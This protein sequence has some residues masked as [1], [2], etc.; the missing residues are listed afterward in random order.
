MSDKS[1][2][3]ALRSEAQLV[4]IEAAAG[5]GKTYQAAEYARDLAP[6]LN[7]NRLLILT[8][9]HAACDVFAERTRDL[10]TQVEIRTIDSLISHIAGAYHLALGL[11][12]DVNAWAR[13]RPDGYT[14]LAT[15]VAALLE[16]APMVATAL[17]QRYPIVICDEHQDSN[18]SQHTIVV[19]IRNVGGRLRVFGDP[20]QSIYGKDTTAAHK[21]W[22]DFC[23][24]ADCVETLNEPHRWENTAAPLGQWIQ[25]ARGSLQRGVPIDLTG[26]L[27]LG[28]NIIRADN[29]AKGYGQYRVDKAEREPIDDVA[30]QRDMGTLVLAAHNKTVRSLCAFFFRRIPIWEGH[31]R[32]NLDLLGRKMS[33]Y[34]GNAHILGEAM[35]NFMKHVAVGFSPS[36]YGDRLLDEIDSRCTKTTRG[37]PK[38]I[39]EIARIILDSPDHHGISHALSR[40]AEL[41]ET[42]KRFNNIK[43]D[44]RHEFYEAIKISEFEESEI[45]IGE[46]AR[47]RTYTRPKPPLKAISTI[48]KAKG[49]ETDNVIVMPCDSKHFKDNDQHRK[50][51]YVAIS[52]AKRKLTLV[53]PQTDPSPLF[54]I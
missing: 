18:V 12:A 14:A 28:L 8:H 37:K 5:C 4:V 39:Q 36:N 26:N 21:Q 43:I 6:T 27:P 3:E 46:L 32:S 10:S 47:R 54:T 40:I 49:L 2:A 7:R 31:V 29:V 23:C 9:T 15:K 45:A 41:V 22:V 48:H 33:E 24:T 25:A 38:R 42:D 30:F 19:T 16:C 35:I 53:I 17:A 20:M 13:I 44:K 52:R 11:P 34:K 51:F 1:V 50:L